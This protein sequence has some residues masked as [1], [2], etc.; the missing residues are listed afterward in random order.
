[1]KITYKCDYALKALLDLAINY[2]KKLVTIPDMA[3]RM[4]IPK[5]FLEQVLLDLKKGGFI[6]S[7]RGKEG[8]YYLLKNPAKITVGEVVRFIEGPLEPIACV[9][10]QYRGC[11]EVSSCVFRPIW[12][13]VASAVQNIVDAVTLQDLVIKMRRFQ[14]APSY[15]I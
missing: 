14:S 4:D 7:K 2:K 13:E 8:G 3:K 12:K 15:V 6:D 10:S 9:A 5:K 1:M 11:G